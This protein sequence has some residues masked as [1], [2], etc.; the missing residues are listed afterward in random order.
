MKKR[1]LPLIALSALLLTGCD[2]F[3]RSVSGQVTGTEMDG[4]SLSAISVTDEK[5]ETDFSVD[6]STAVFFNLDDPEGEALLNHQAKV[7]VEYSLLQWPF[8]RK[9][10]DYVRVNSYLS[11]EKTLSDGTGVEVWK[12]TFD[13]SYRLPDGTLLLLERDPSG[14]DNVTV[15]GT[16]NF[17]DLGP[18][19]QEEILGYYDGQGLLY[20]LDALLEEAYGVYQE[21][22][23]SFEGGMV[24][25]RTHPTASG[26][27]VVYYLT[28]V[29]LPAAWDN[30]YGFI[31]Y[32]I[33]T[34]QAFDRETGEKLEGWS[35]F[36]CSPEEAVEAILDAAGV[37]DPT[38][39]ADLAAYLEPEDLIFFSDNLEFNVP[40][41]TFA[42][43]KE[44]YF[45][46]YGADLTGT[47]RDLLKPGAVPVAPAE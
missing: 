34:G 24:E 16:E 5:K 14:P 19:A 13:T 43:Q 38:E 44:G 30:D 45:S 39:R 11:G 32:E 37:E 27:E 35:L 23:D 28:S 10:A 33:R 26:E 41:S 2:A 15:G 12:N 22:P 8:G 4:E 21:D 29:S 18:A 42:W 25:Q 40:P 46:G 31:Q 47:L 36:T 17:D 1:W 6:P 20:D 7:T 3:T 9:K